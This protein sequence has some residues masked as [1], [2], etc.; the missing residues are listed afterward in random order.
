MLQLNVESMQLLRACLKNR[1]PCLIK[2]IESSDDNH[3]SVD[4]YNEL[5]HI[6]G[7]E[8]ISNG[9]NTNWEP[10]EYGLKLENLIDEI[11]RFFM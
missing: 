7:D 3:Y 6:V 1:N 9:F 11:G 8:L 4:F 10:N 2:K 5:R